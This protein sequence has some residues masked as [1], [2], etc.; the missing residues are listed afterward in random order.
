MVDALSMDGMRGVVSPRERF[1][2]GLS[3]GAATI[4]IVVIVA[5]EMVVAFVMR[6][7]VMQALAVSLPPSLRDAV[8][9]NPPAPLQWNWL[10]AA[11]R[12]LVMLGLWTTLLFIA[13]GALGHVVRFTRVATVVACASVVLAAKSAFTALI[14][15]L[16]GVDAIQHVSDVQPVIGLDLLV[17]PDSPVLQT[18]LGAVNV[19]D[20]WFVCLLC[21]ALARTEA[22]P[23][24]STVTAV[25]AVWLVM[26][27]G[28]TTMVYFVS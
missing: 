12:P 15:Q 3:L 18:I 27:A 21:L 4:P 24:G 5:V 2:P 6:P 7:F 16:R 1:S 19:F 10:F 9:A 17:G 28:R 26:L 13:F 25:V 11:V 8:I 14:L 23:I 22:K 20:V